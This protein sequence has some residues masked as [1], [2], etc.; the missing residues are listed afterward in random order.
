MPERSLPRRENAVFDGIADSYDETRSLSPDVTE[1][2]ARVL[3]PELEGR[4]RCLEIGVGTGR[5]ALPL[6]ARGI[7]VAGID[8]S[9]RMIGRLVEKAGGGPPFPL[10][11]ADALRLPFRESTFGAG[12]IAHVLHLIPAWNDALRELV[13]VV[14]PGGVILVDVARWDLRLMQ[15][16]QERFASEA[17][18]SPRFPGTTEESEIEEAMRGLGASVRRLPAIPAPQL[19]TIEEHIGRMERG[20]YSFCAGLGPGARRIAAGATR[21]WAQERFGRLD[22]P[23]E[24]GTQIVWLAFDLTNSAIRDEISSES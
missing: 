2:V 14:E 22:E 9:A 20:I 5:I 11:L 3:E 6:H 24:I 19:A 15:D 1:A 4:G 10:A 7:P 13:R 18:I 23:R 8:L 16:V 12:V 21:R 17:G